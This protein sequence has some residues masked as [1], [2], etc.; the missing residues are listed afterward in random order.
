MFFELTWGAE[1]LRS[2]QEPEPAL[3]GVQVPTVW[4]QEFL[5]LPRMFQRLDFGFR[6]EK[7]EAQELLVSSQLLLYLAS[8]D[9]WF[10][11]VTQARL[12]HLQLAAG[13]LC[14]LHSMSLAA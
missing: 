2:R 12:Q 6:E 5:E 1:G 8:L 10:L 11:S 3:T 4:F 9:F 14:T 7:I 13:W